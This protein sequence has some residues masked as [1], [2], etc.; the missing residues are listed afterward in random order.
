MQAIWSHIAR[1]QGLKNSD[2]IKFDSAVIEYIYNAKLRLRDMLMKPVEDLSQ[3]K[4]AAVKIFKDCDEEF[5][6]P[7]IDTGKEVVTLLYVAEEFSKFWTEKQVYS[8]DS[9]SLSD[10]L[11][12]LTGFS[13]L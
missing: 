7:S 9:S 2:K 6:H 4:A 10:L 11:S 13:Q 12:D 1:P 5:G 8:N 3:F